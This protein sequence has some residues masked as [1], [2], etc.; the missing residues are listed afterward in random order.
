MKNVIEVQD[1][2][3]IYRQRLLEVQ[4]LRGLSLQVN[5]GEM[6]AITGPSGSG[7]STLLHLLG[8]LDTPSQGLVKILDQDISTLNDKQL[9]SFRRQKLGFVFQFFN[10]LP[11]LTARENAALPLLLDNIPRLK[12]LDKADTLLQRVGLGDRL[13]HRPDELSGGQQ[14]RVALARALVAQPQILLADEPTGNLDSKAS[15][16]VLN[17]LEELR[18]ETQ[19]TMIL[20]THDDRVAARA[21]RNLHLIDGQIA[22]DRRSPNPNGDSP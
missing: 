4:A 8:A 3:K 1:A 14:Q 15:A 16:E 18:Q 17:L 12:A 6:I 5:S 13:Q 22:Q 20:V 7:K 2:W 9:A 11:T 10:L 19:I 21:E